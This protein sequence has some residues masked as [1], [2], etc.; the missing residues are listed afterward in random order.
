MGKTER[1][2][3]GAS[4]ATLLFFIRTA[5]LSLEL[6]VEQEF[7]QKIPFSK[8]ITLLNNYCRYN[9]SPAKKPAIYLTAIKG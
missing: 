9:R 6:K 2:P 1:H 4:S 3:I 5:L 8:R 7:L